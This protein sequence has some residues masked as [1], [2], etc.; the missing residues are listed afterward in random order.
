MRTLELLEQRG[1][2]DRFLSQ[3]QVI[4]RAPFVGGTLDVSDMPTRHSHYLV[5][6]QTHTERILADWVSEQGVP[7]YRGKAVTDLQQQSDG[8]EV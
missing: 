1:I 8:V 2:A 5:L 7:V 4:L 3:G 6:W